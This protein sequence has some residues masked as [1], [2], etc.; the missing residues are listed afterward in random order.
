[1]GHIMGAEGSGGGG[2]EGPPTFAPPRP[3]GL[4]N[5][6]E[7]LIGGDGAGHNL[8]TVSGGRR[9]GDGRSLLPGGGKNEQ[10][11]FIG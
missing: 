6:W 4:S 11:Y 7:G 10:R 5:P 8:P 9:D 3:I 2:D 1:M